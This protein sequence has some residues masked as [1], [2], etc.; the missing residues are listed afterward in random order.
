VTDASPAL[1]ADF[2]GS[3]SGADTFIQIYDASDLSVI[4]SSNDDCENADSFGA[5]SSPNASCFNTITGPNYESCTCATAPTGNYL[6]REA[7]NPPNGGAIRVNV[8]KKAACGQAILGSCCVNNG[9]A[10]GCTDNVVQAACTGSWSNQ[11]CADRAPCVCVP[12]CAGR[13]CG[14][15][16]CGGSCGT[17]NDNNGCTDDSCSAAGQCV[18][19][20]NT[21][22]CNDG[23]ACTSNDT[24]SGG[25]CGGTAVDCND[26]NP[27]TTDA[28][29]PA[30][31]CTHT[32]NSNACDDGNP[33]TLNDVCG[34]GSCAGTLNTCDDGV[35]CTA[36]SCN[37]A[38]GTCS[39]DQSGCF[40]PIPTVSQWGIA[41]MA[42]LLLIG[43]KIYFTRRQSTTA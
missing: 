34:G 38:D 31:G 42:L 22:P 15:D 40:T 37:T 17:C 30:S 29:A 28:C 21:A 2:C 4:L 18:F 41:V 8:N 9:P 20:N 36:D 33:C 10:F 23:S 35:D 13:V 7:S 5:G 43:A 25:Q 1:E 19:T 6:I 24:C 12:N 11:K 3:T 39:H 26:N 32:N 16:G 27:C 14:D